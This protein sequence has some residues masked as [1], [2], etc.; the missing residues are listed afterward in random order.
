MKAIFANHV[1]QTSPFPIGLEIVSAEGIYLQAI[2]GKQYIDCTSGI[3]V[4]NLGHGHQAIINAIKK[5]ADKHLHTMVY[6]EFIEHPQV[7]YAQ[8][9]TSQL[10]T[11]LNCLYYCTSGS[12]AVEASMKLAKRKTG[13]TELVSFIGA[14]HGSTH[15]ALSMMGSEI[16][17][18]AY[19]PL[20]PGVSH[21]C[22]NSFLD[23]EMITTKTAGV[24]VEPI[25]AA[26]GITLADVEWLKALR[27]RCNQVGAMLIFDEVQTG[28]GRTGKLFA[29]EHYQVQPDVL[30]L[31][32]AMGGGMPIGGLVANYEDLQLFTHQP[33]LGHINTFG[34]NAIACAAAL[35]TLETLLNEP[36]LLSEVE[37]K[38]NLLV[39]QLK[40]KSIVKI[41][42]K[43]LLHAVHFASKQE[44]QR[45]MQNAL[46][47]QIVIIG[48]LLNDHA[49]R[50][51]PPLTVTPNEINDIAVKLLNCF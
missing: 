42:G 4:N 43:G 18:H 20:L 38:G 11:S 16:Y 12:E 3:A 14:Y 40:H 51:A 30:L 10:P 36:D 7:K 5:Q 32:K 41:T 24:I 28:F 39:N 15:G 47:Q 19:R 46:D 13:R 27:A 17:K 29:F 9:L 22:Y 1:G 49:V 37:E 50:I 26:S 45:F 8:L 33:I 44:A 2:D 34:G 25:Q 48:F 31:A 35:A 21:L 23:L 6:G